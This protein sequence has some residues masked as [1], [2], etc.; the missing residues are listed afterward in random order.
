MIKVL[1]A[2]DYA[3][4]R[5]GLRMLISV[6]S[7]LLVIGEAADGQIAVET[8]ERLRPDVVLMDISM[9]KVNGL[10]A[11][12]R[13][14][15]NSPGTSVLLMTIHD[16]DEM[17]AKATAAGAFGLLSKNTGTIMLTHAIRQAW[18]R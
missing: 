10:E 5:Q 13:I 16:S 9:P 7:D 4:V 8:T 15:E 14:R 6:C 17:R 18:I 2:D 11:T 3:P 12:E 1:I